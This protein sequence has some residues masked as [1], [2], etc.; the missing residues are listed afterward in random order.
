MI[1]TALSGTPRESMRDALISIEAPTLAKNITDVEMVVAH[2]HDGDVNA[3]NDSS[4]SGRELR[5]QLAETL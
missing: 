1:I 5:Q 4:A 3:E 2:D